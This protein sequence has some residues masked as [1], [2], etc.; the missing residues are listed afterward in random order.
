MYKEVRGTGWKALVERIGK[1]V[2]SAFP[3][4]LV[5]PGDM[6]LTGSTVEVDSFQDTN[7]ATTVEEYTKVA[8][9]T[10]IE[11]HCESGAIRTLSSGDACTATT[12]TPVPAGDAV[13]YNEDSV[14]VYFVQE[15]IV[16]VVSR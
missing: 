14:S 12:G 16:T 10:K 5:E 4:Y 2:K 1:T 11:I 15:S 13:A 6:R 9:A 8:G 3:V 7:V